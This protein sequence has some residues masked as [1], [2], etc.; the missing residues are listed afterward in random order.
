MKKN[1]LLYIL[2]IFLIVV[3]GF[4]LFNYLGKSSDKSRKGPKGPGNFIAKQLEFDEAQMQRFQELNQE[5]RQVMRG[6]LNE[7]KDLKEELF[8]KISETNI[9]DKEI[10]SI[11]R[12]IG[13]K[14]QQKE[15]ETFKNLKN[16][17]EICNDKQKERFNKIVRDAMHRGRKRG[18]GPPR[19]GEGPPRH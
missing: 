5:H 16:I 12:L 18:D 13:I 11:T 9:S 2:L 4:F 15:K 8:K 17:Q 6:L 19:R 14:E 7:T 10:D 3:N 1:L